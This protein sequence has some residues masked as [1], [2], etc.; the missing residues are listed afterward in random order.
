[1]APRSAAIGEFHGEPSMEPREVM[2]QW[3]LPLRVSD[4]RRMLVTLLGTLGV[5]KTPLLGPARLLR[6]SALDA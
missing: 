2:L 6:V 5:Y 4:Q 1:L 3:R